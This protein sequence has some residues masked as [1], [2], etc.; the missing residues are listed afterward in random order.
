[1]ADTLESFKAKP[2]LT[3]EEAIEEH[4]RFMGDSLKKQALKKEA[5]G[6]GEPKFS[7]YLP[8][9]LRTGDSET[10]AKK[11]IK[12][13]FED[14][15]GFVHSASPNSVMGGQIIPTHV[16]IADFL[17]CYKGQ[18]IAIEVKASRVGISTRRSQLAQ[19]SR[20]YKSKG[21]S[22]IAHSVAC[23]EEYEKRSDDWKNPQKRKEHDVDKFIASQKRIPG[24]QKEAS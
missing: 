17:I 14:R 19:L 12:K 6:D 11:L 20:V 21:H 22:L 4:R 7:L 18:F 10:R 8:K 13:Y 16:G 5:L 24:F 1:M 23:L 3:F 2:E 15:G 9:E